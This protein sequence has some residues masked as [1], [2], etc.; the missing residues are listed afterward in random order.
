[1]PLICRP[2]G[3]I[4]DGHRRWRAAMLDGKPAQLDTIIIDGDLTEARIKEIQLITALHRADLKPFELYSGCKSWL[5]LHPGMAA[6]GLAAAI[7]VTEAHLSKVLSLDK[8]IPP[9]KTAASEGKLGVSDWYAM[10]RASET[11][12]ALLLSAKL[13]GEITSR[14]QMRDQTRKARNG[15]LP[16]VRVSRVKCAMPSGVSVTLAGVG[17]GLTLDD[18]I[19][20]LAELLKEAKKAND[21]GLDSK[22]FS[23]VMR[24]KSKVS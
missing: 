11:D 10:S 13:S 19:E 8:C 6:K 24:D 22:T 1:V 3:I 18:V 21:Q 14:E 20:T 2:C 5:E 4:V 12:Q 15:G 9:V 17:Q 16:T 7:D 23:A